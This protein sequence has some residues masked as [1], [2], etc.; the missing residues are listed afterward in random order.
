[1]MFF[2]KKLFCH[3]ERSEGSIRRFTGR[4]SM[5]DNRSSLSFRMTNFLNRFSP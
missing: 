4:R 1:M 5:A 3:P 2:E